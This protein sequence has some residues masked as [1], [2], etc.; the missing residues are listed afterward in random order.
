MS[1]TSGQGKLTGKQKAFA[2]AYVGPARFNGTEAARIATYAEPSVEASRLLRNAKVQ[3]YI[4]ETHKQQELTA[5]IV[6][7]LVEEDAKRSDAD[8][9]KL[10]A[11]APSVP[12]SASAVSAFLAARTTARTNLLK[13]H[14]ILAD[15]VNVK[16]S[17]R[18]DHVHRNPDLKA[19]TDDELNALEEMAQRLTAEAV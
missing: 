11:K 3:A 18:V 8:I 9:L 12:A 5:E 10:A 2:D 16:H 17:G 4:S 14:N 15:R 6:L 1:D 19:L 7:A 13:V